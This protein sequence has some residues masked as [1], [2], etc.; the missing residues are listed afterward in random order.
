M[1]STVFSFVS[2]IVNAPRAEYSRDIARYFVTG[3]S[4]ENHNYR[5]GLVFLGCIIGGIAAIWLF[6]LLVL[7]CKGRKSVGCAAGFAFERR[8]ADD[9]VDKYMDDGQDKAGSTDMDLTDEEDAVDTNSPTKQSTTPSKNVPDEGVEVDISG[10][11]ERL[12]SDAVDDLSF[13]SS[14]PSNEL[15]SSSI[16]SGTLSSVPSD[17]Y[18]IETEFL[19]PSKRERRTQCAFLLFGLI[20]LTSIPLI[21]A[22][23]FSPFKQ[24]AEATFEQVQDARDV[25]L[26]IQSSMDAISQGAAEA[27]KM[28]ENAELEVDVLCPEASKTFLNTSLIGISSIKMIAHEVQSNFSLIQNETIGQVDVVDDLFSK[29]EVA[30]D[31]FEDVYHTSKNYI[32]AVPAILM[33]LA[34]LTSVPLFG[35]IM[36]WRQKS[37]LRLQRILSYGVLPLLM[38][39][40]VVCWIVAIATAISTATGSD[41]CAYGSA[42]GSP[43]DAIMSMVE[44][45]GIK[46]S[47]VFY[48]FAYTYTNGC[49]GD[50]PTEA[51]ASLEDQLKVAEDSIWIHLSVIDAT[52]REVVLEQCGGGDALTEFLADTRDLAQVL[53]SIRKSLSSITDSL[54]CKR[55][56]PIYSQI[57][58]QSLCTDA[59][60]ATAWGFLLFFVVSISSLVLVTLRASWI[61]KIAEDRVYE[62]SE[63]AENMI[64]D[65]HE[66]YLAYISKYRHEWQEYGGV[67]KDLAAAAK[68]EALSPTSSVPEECPIVQIMPQHDPPQSPYA[69]GKLAAQSF[70][71]YNGSDIDANSLVTSISFP[72][73]RDP[74]ETPDE[75]L[76]VGSPSLLLGDYEGLDAE[77]LDRMLA[78]STSGDNT[79]SINSYRY[80][81]NGAMK[82]ITPAGLDIDSGSSQDSD[83]SPRAF[84]FEEND[85]NDL[86]PS[87]PERSHSFRITSLAEKLEPE[88]GA[89]SEH[90]TVFPQESETQANG[91]FSFP[92]NP[93]PP[94]EDER[95]D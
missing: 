30:F 32:W 61:Y 89:W 58:E 63:V 80:S 56:N 77:G 29:V 9:H 85:D 45:Q 87:A 43:S 81:L 24:S 34:I 83:S 4:T 73:L 16:G 19:E 64:V 41:F 17:G 2:N 47:S 3:G 11:Q 50:D 42:S 62:E 25:F 35:V 23:A 27:T 40:S 12:A 48:D 86:F 14:I 57:V 78:P 49:R 51:L 22:F 44:R 84:I 74:G 37:S 60:G 94:S 92:S 67:D 53:S 1:Q 52:G 72:S 13:H 82:A 90:G 7:K 55:I 26:S 20:T 15:D 46:N 66:E 93:D 68:P 70:D 5:A 8:V 65:E 28:V 69:Q 39:F 91:T 59:V 75:E 76:I 79:M 33:G 71:P 38:A 95:Y 18:S 6:I 21:L 54:A 10:I 36:A 88:S 31:G